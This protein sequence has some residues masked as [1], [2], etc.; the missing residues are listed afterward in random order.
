VLSDLARHR[1]CL[2]VGGGQRG[3][4]RQVGHAPEF[5][6]GLLRYEPEVEV[7]RALQHRQEIDAL[8]P[9]DGLDRRPESRGSDPVFRPSYL[10]QM[11][12]SDR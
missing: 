1:F 8:D 9:G 6:F 4:L 5:S 10:R 12:Q 2:A 11:L 7:G 3:L